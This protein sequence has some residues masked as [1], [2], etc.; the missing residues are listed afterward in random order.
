MLHPW[1]TLK[2]MVGAVLMTAAFAIVFLSC[3]KPLPPPAPPTDVDAGAAT[4]QTACARLQQL[5]CPA[6]EP[7]PKGVPCLE[8][9]LRVQE[10]GLIDWNLDCV[11]RAL[12][13]GATD[14]CAR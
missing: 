6:G 7:T 10:S 11:A 8:V 13:C 1:S 12:T 9:C 5:G 2:I 4:C 3:T 14:R